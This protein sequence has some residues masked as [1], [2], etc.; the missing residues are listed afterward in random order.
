MPDVL[1]V[2]CSVVAKWALPESGIAAA[3]RILEWHS[4]GEIVLVA[5]DILLAEFAS[6]LAK[7]SRRKLISAERAGEAF[8]LLNRG[9]LR[10]FDMRPRLP[11]ALELALRYHLSLWDCIYLAMAIDLDCPVITADQRLFRGGA[12]RQPSILLMQQEVDRRSKASSP[13]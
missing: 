12:G 7:R 3:D 11:L 8:R 10:L 5:P 1:V 9:V 6:L 2:D 13:R 4:G